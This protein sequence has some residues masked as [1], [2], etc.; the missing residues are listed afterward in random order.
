MVADEIQEDAPIDLPGRS[1]GGSL[2]SLGVDLA[3]EGAASQ[4][5]EAFV[6]YNAKLVSSSP[7]SQPQV[8]SGPLMWGDFVVKAPYR[9]KNLDESGANGYL[10]GVFAFLTTKSV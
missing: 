1:P 10:Y 9:K 3:H 7:S 6:F 5:V 2:E 8:G 4:G